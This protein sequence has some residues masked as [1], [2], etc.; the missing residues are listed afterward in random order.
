MGWESPVLLNQTGVYNVS[1]AAAL[2]AGLT[3]SKI[4]KIPINSTEYYLVENR[5]R[6]VNKN[7]AI[8]NINLNGQSLIKTFPK[9]TTGFSSYSIDSLAGVVT[10]VDEYDWAVPG[11]GIVVWHIDENVINAKLSTNK[12]NTE[13]FNRGVDVEEADGIQDIG[14]QFTTIFGDQVI[15]EGD[16]VDLWYAGNKSKFYTNKFDSSTKPNTNSNTGANS[17]ISFEGF[18]VSKNIM[19]FKLTLGSTNIALVESFESQVSDIDKITYANNRSFVLSNNSL[20]S[21]NNGQNDFVF[22]YSDFSNKE[23]M[24]NEQTGIIAGVFNSKINVYSINN[25]AVYSLELNEKITT[26]PAV[27]ISGDISFI[28]I[29]TISG[30]VYN[31]NIPNLNTGQI[32]AVLDSY[33]SDKQIVQSFYV[34]GTPCVLDK[35]HLSGFSFNLDGINEF[36]QVAVFKKA[37]NSLSFIARDNQNTFYIFEGASLT[38]SFK[39]SSMDSIKSFILCDLFHTG[40]YQI[41]FTDSNYIY[42]YLLSGAVVDGFPIKAKTGETFTKQ[43]LAADFDGNG[44]SEIMYFTTKGKIYAYTPYEQKMLTGFPISC[45][46]EI[47]GYPV[48]YEMFE[49][50]VNKIV[51]NLINSNNC[52]YSY[53][54]DYNSANSTIYFNGKYGNLYNNSFLVSAKTENVITEYFPENK[55]YNWPNPVY[56]NSTNIRYYVSEDSKINIKIFDLAGGFVQELNDYAAGGLDSEITWDVTNIQSGVYLARVEATGNSGK[57]GNKIIKIAVI[58]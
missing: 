51:L 37:D 30:K 8:L 52:F 33:V 46:S 36:D 48:M 20:Y 11:N 42:S 50:G 31:I 56:E 41:V 54:I 14:E 25:D 26:V 22:K 9:D 6:D 27:I 23:L 4:Y 3:D 53:K 10:D 28:Q 55:I 12:I 21:K 15:G 58:K 38:N 5:Q 18:S 44:Y 49:G 45:G 1:V 13:K 32:T 7:G 34:S 17:L 57:S 16:S 35:K 19:N 43:V 2:A 24:T 29:G 39:I 40:D 47:K